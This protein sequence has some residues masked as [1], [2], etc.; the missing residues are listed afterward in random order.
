MGIRFNRIKT[1]EV[2]TFDAIWDVSE[3]GEAVLLGGEGDPR[4]L[5]VARFD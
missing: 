5:S 3:N 2:G 4:A 1:V